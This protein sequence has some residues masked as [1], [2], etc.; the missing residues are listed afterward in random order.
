VLPAVLGVVLGELIE[1]NYRR[2]LLLSDGDYAIFLE[3]RIAIA[4]FVVAIII[5]TVSLVSE[6]RRAK[7]PRKEKV[8]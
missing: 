3:D 1:A 2:S 6:W 4:F 7:Q 5:T 8:M